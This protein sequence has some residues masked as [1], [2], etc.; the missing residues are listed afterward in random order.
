ML[1]NSAV[2]AYLASH[3]T[4]KRAASISET[5]RIL[6][7]SAT[8]GLELFLLLLLWIGLR[9]NRTSLADLIGGR[10]NSPEDFMI[11]VG[12]AIGFWV[13]AY[14]VLIGLSFAMG[15]A[16][17]SN[18]DEAKRLADML[19]PHTVK[20][21]GI[22]IGLSMIAGFVEELIFRGYLQRQLGALTGNIYVGLVLS[23]LVFGAGHGYEGT[24]RMILIFVYGGMFGF[25]ALWRRSL[26]PGMM[27][28]A[29][30]DAFQGIVLFI[31]AH[32]GL[33][34]MH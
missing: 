25:L 15:L 30:H 19:A 28:H 4:N 24:R 8:I 5:A 31:A 22:F 10:W 18:V 21:L 9:M 1:A 20:A 2:S 13:A 26:R 27:A 34:S 29:W 16:K 33:L 17:P 11:D 14:G 32:K 7:Y 23:A 12:L 6:Q 3:V